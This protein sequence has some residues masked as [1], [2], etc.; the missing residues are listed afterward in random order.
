MIMNLKVD[1]DLHQ[2][3]RIEAAEKHISM[4]TALAGILNRHFGLG[5]GL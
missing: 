5:S 4:Q 2:A 1:A 3:L